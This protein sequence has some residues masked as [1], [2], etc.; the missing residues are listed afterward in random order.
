MRWRSTRRRPTAVR[1][2][3]DGRDRAPAR[4]GEALDLVPA[5]AIEL[6]P[7]GR[8]GDHRLALHHHAE[9][10]P[11]AVRHRV[12]VAGG[13]APQLP[14][15]GAEL[16]PPQPL[17]VGVALPAGDQ[18][19]DR[20]ALLGAQLF[21]VLGVDDQAVG[22][23]LLERDRAGVAGAIGALEE[24][25]PRV[26][27]DPRFL[28]QPGDRHAGPLRTRQQ[29]VAHLHVRRRRL[30]PVGE[31]VAG[32]FEEM[33]LRD[34]RIAH[35]VAHREHERL[36][37]HAVDDEPMLLRVDLGHAGVVT[38]EDQAVRRHDAVLMLERRHA[39]VGPALAVDQDPAAPAHDVALEADR[40]AVARVRDLGAHAPGPFRHVERFCARRRHA[41]RPGQQGG[42][43]RGRPTSE[44]RAPR[45]RSRAVVRGRRKRL[46]DPHGSA[47]FLGRARDL[48]GLPPSVVAT[49]DG[50]AC[51]TSSL[52]PWL[53]PCF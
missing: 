49:R 43:D 30:G 31:R 41:G 22:E 38:L 37:H 21:A 27:L 6:H 39:P 50:R 40:Q 13:L 5:G 8:V 23:R 45:L 53:L 17:D 12:G 1:G 51:P 18:Q 46:P 11:F 19:P 4:P 44:E 32:A 33:K 16:D 26:R 47:P 34:R 20:I 3:V 9:L 25:P 29:P 28:E 35:Q 42:A 52:T 36:A 2:D 7:A 15:L 24:H 14:G 48:L 10:A